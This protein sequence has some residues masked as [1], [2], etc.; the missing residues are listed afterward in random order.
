MTDCSLRVIFSQVSGAQVDFFVR[1]G[2]VL[3]QREQEMGDGKKN[4]KQGCTG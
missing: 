2:D 4:G 3:A 1:K